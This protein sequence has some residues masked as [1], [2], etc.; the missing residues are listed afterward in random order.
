MKYNP[1]FD[2][3]SVLDA[4]RIINEKYKEGSQEDEALRI[5]AVALLYI[6]ENRK[7]DDYRD[8][9]RSF[10]TP[11]IDSITVS[12]TFSSREEADAWLASG[13]AQEG[14]LVRVAGQGFQVIPMR[15]GTGLTLLRTP[16]P[17]ELMK[18]Y[19]PDTE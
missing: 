3:D 12:Q 14:E 18:K 7:L 17:E 9:F 1:D 13:K 2:V 19:P 4:L 16:L 5:A 10:Y 8:F 15:Q 11:A 6:R